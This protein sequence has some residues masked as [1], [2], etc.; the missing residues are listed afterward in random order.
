MATPFK[1]EFTADPSQYNAAMDEIAQKSLTSF[2]VIQSAMR[3]MTV[4]T[5]SSVQQSMDGIK[6]SFSSLTSLASSMRGVLASVG[7]ALSAGAFVSAI[8]GSLDFAEGLNKLKQQLGDTVE[9][10]SG[11][12]YAFKQ[13][14]V[15]RE[16]WVKGLKTLATQMLDA[17]TGGKEAKAVF[18]SVGVAFEAAPGQLR[19]TAEVLL[20]IAD[21]FEQMEDGAA[22]TALSIKLFGRN[23][24][25]LIPFLNQGRAGIEALTKEARRLGV[26]ISDEAAEKAERFNDSL[27]AVKAAADGAKM[28]MGMNRTAITGSRKARCSLIR[29]T[30]TD[31]LASKM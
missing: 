20:T 8:K 31:Q 17:A 16:S 18:D 2:Q 6:G 9:N 7:I 24:L 19:P 4:N 10:L 12:D 25:E 21:R 27:K 23:G 29:R 22:K 30:G 1:T 5:G 3:E 13:G 15:S 28:A 11:L 26:V 14:D